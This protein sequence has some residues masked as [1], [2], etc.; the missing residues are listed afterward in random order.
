M[1]KMSKSTKKKHFLFDFDN[2]IVDTN[3]YN[4]LI[5]SKTLLKYD[6]KVSD[7]YINEFFAKHIGNTIREIYTFIVKELDKELSVDE[8]LETDKTMQISNVSNVKIINGFFELL[9][10]LIEERKT[11]HIYTNRR[12]DTLQPILKNLGLLKYFS[13]IVS[14]VDVGINKPDIDCLGSLK[15]DI[16]NNSDY[17]YIGDSDV[18]AEFAKNLGIDYFFI[19]RY[20]EEPFRELFKLV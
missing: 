7:D 10:R 3:E 1:L 19:D 18:D 20:S 16:L 17:V 2:T 4:K 15:M 13:N 14:C 11:L 8:L 6:V 9:E 12:M 5:F